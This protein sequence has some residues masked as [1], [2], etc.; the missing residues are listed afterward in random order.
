MSETPCYDE[1]RYLIRLADRLESLISAE[2]SGL[3]DWRDRANALLHSQDLESLTGERTLDDLALQLRR[4]WLHFANSVSSRYFRSPT[5]FQ[6]PRL[7]SG[8][9]APTPYDRWMQPVSLEQRASGYHPAPEGWRADHVLFN[10]GMG[11]VTCLLPVLRTMFQPRT[12]SPLRMHGLGGYFEIMD[13]ITANNDDLF[14]ASIFRDQAQL[15]TSVSSGE[16]QVI[17]V[18]PVSCRFDLDVFDLDAFLDAWKQRPQNIPGVIVF[19]TTLTANR[20]PIAEVLQRLQPGKPWAVVQFSSVL[21]LDQEGLE[22]SNGGL[23]SVYSV[24]AG[25]MED[26]SFRMR[27]FRSAMGLGLTMDQLAMLDYPGFM[28]QAIIER[29]ANAIF[30]NNAYLAKR[31]DTGEDLLFDSKSHPV[32]N[33]DTEYPWAVAPFVYFQLRKGSDKE[34]LQL[35]KHVFYNEAEKR[36]LTFMPGSSFGFRGHRC[37]LGG[38]RDVPGYE[39]IRVAMGARKGPNV[40]EAVKLL[41]DLGLMRDFGRIREMYPELVDVARKEAEQK[42]KYFGGS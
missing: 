40:D 14:Q 36:G 12:D 28:D 10:T 18:E 29:H 23:M 35:L 24:N 1:C 21:K 38:I 34:D 15:R 20:F 4:E 3:K 17:Y 27:R 25:N 42:K 30:E 9:A 26:F 32:L 13:L 7:P 16:S 11:V 8:S 37:E 31:V 39:T 2:N 6:L 19:D 5:S 22:F 33:G 41:N